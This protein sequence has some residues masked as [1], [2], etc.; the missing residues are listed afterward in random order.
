[1]DAGTS[2]LPLIDE[3][4][5]D[6][7]AQKQSFSGVVTVVVGDERRYERVAGFAHRA[8]EV[9]NTPTT[10]FAIASGGKTFTALAVLRLIEQ[11]VF[12]LETPVRG[13]LGADLP[14]IDDAVTIEH[15][16]THTSGIGD[17]LDEEA[18]WDP[19]DY[20]LPVPVHLLADT[21][22]FVPV[23]DGFPQAFRPG[24]R[25]AYCNG[26]YI[27]LALIAE[28]AGGREYHELVEAEVCARAG[29]VK[30]SFLRSDELPGDAAL[31][32]LFARGDRTNVLH[33]PVRGNGD[34]GIYTTA[35]DLHAFWRALTSGRIIGASTFAQMTEPRFDVPSER[36]RYGLGVYL[37]EAGPQL[38]MEGYDAGVSFRST[39][40][41]VTCTTVTVLGNS[42]EGAWPL[43]SALADL[44]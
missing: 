11:G 39:H 6:H 1:M 36:M 5:V 30:T 10:R 24:E 14:L 40:N 16:L 21:E 15:L 3:S 12:A 44:A 18:D 33:L 37:G 27:V 38:V 32:Y 9:P 43:V 19:A 29:L 25:F 22:A 8:L 35:G 34:G 31:G 4:A 17:Y 28:R 41:P 26:G 23:I 2:G 7:A 42:S 20:V 13:I